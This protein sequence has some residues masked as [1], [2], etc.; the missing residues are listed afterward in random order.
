MLE[1]PHCFRKHYVARI[2][3]G[4]DACKV[5]VGKRE[6]RRPLRRP[7]RRWEDNIKVNLQDVEYGMYWIDLAEDGNWWRAVLKEVM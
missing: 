2:G 7:T 4:R 5:L 3:E 1:T 6:G